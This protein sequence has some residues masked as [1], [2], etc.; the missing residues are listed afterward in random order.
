MPKP[1]LIP[2]YW[3]ALRSLQNQQKPVLVHSKG[4]QASKVISTAKAGTLR[5]SR[6]MPPEYY[7]LSENARRNALRRL[8]ARQLYY[9]CSYLVDAVH[10]RGRIAESDYWLMEIGLRLLLR[11]RDS[12]KAQ[13]RERYAELVRIYR[14]SGGY[15]WACNRAGQYRVKRQPGWSVSGAKVHPLSKASASGSLYWP[16]T[17]EPSPCPDCASVRCVDALTQIPYCFNRRCLKS[18]WNSARTGRGCTS[19]AQAKGALRHPS[20]PQNILNN[21]PRRRSASEAELV[22]QEMQDLINRIPG[23]AELLQRK[24]VHPQP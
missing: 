11:L 16:E 22:G 23:A 9:C 10:W 24:R 8:S 5:R 3:S 17:Y 13:D 18:R 14:S 2:R 21:E 6:N 15:A 19:F 12:E 20:M 7:L 1:N 4:M